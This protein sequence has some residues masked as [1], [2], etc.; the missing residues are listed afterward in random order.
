MSDN[1]QFRKVSIFATGVVFLF[2]LL[3]TI[4]FAG[5]R[6]ALAFGEAFYSGILLEYIIVVSALVF[7]AGLAGVLLAVKARFQ[8][9]SIITIFVSILLALAGFSLF[10]MRGR[11][12]VAAAA[13]LAVMGVQAAVT[14]GFMYRKEIVS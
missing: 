14:F 2:W 4:I 6:H 9:A 1:K 12:I 3:L 13:I 7:C 10:W 11:V 5:K 8:F